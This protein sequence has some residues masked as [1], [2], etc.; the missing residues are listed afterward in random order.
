MTARH[1][2]GSTISNVKVGGRFARSA[3]P[4]EVDSEATLSLGNGTNNELSKEKELSDL[5]KRIQ[6]TTNFDRW[7]L[8]SMPQELWK[9]YKDIYSWRRECYVLK[10]FARLNMDHILGKPDPKGTLFVYDIFTHRLGVY[11]MY[12]SI[13]GKQGWGP[14]RHTTEYVE[15]HNIIMPSDFAPHTKTEQNE[16][17]YLAATCLAK[18]EAD[19]TKYYDWRVRTA[20]WK[21]D[22]EED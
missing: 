20:V 13:D 22:S 5:R 3:S 2:K 18:P 16:L 19:W 8:G 15:V 1:L 7:R 6:R 4:Q 9:R 11:V 12:P 17:A 14:V 21:L 10:T